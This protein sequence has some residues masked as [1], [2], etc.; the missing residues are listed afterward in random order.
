VPNTSALD[1][2]LDAAERLPLDAQEELV[3]I[4]RRR[5]AEHGRERIL[6]DILESRKEFAEGKCRP[7]TP[8]E[9]MREIES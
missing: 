3:S 2:V 8:D 4:L 1:E 9:I 6:A 5:L 7:A